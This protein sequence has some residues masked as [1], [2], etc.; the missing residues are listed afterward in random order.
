MKK[1]CWLSLSLVW[2]VSCSVSVP[3]QKTYVINT[4]P[5]VPYKATTRHA[6]LLVLMPQ[7]NSIYNTTS[8]AYTTY[9]YQV[10]YFARNA[11]ADTPAKMLQPLMA[12]TLQNT[13]HFHAVLTLPV[14]RYSYVLATQVQQLQQDFTVSPSVVRLRIHAQ[15]LSANSNRLIAEQQFSIVKTMPSKNPYGGVIAANQ[16]TADFLSQLSEFCLNNMK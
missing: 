13:H 7:T 3:Q 16:A 14:G 10:A 2:L 5:S 12:Q 11:W 6:S 15:L 4:V 8:M 9:P 1:L